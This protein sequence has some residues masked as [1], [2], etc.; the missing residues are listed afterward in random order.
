MALLCGLEPAPVENCRVL[1]LACGEGANLIPM[2][3]ELP[4]SRFVGFDAAALSIT[5]GYETIDAL[6]LSNIE[7]TATSIQDL[8]PG[9]GEFDYIVAHGVYS[10]VPEEVRDALLAV[11]KRHLAPHGVAYVSY[12]AYPGGHFRELVREMMLF[13]AGEIED[14]AQ[15]VGGGI[16]FVRF[17]R[18]LHPEQ[19]PY[20]AVLDLELER[21]ASDPNYVFHDDF[22]ETNTPVYFSQFAEHAQSHGL[23][24]LAEASMVFFGDPLLKGDTGRKLRELSGKNLIAREQ[25]L[26]FIRGT[27][28][29]QSLLCH[30][31][32]E[33][34][35]EPNVSRLLELYAASA[36]RPD[37]KDPD[38]RSDSVLS[39]KALGGVVEVRQPL[40]KSAFF[41]LGE[42]W[43]EALRISDLLARARE[44]CGQPQASEPTSEELAMFSGALLHAASVPVLDLWA[45][46]PRFV[47]K[48]SERPMASPLCRLQI[49]QGDIVT[50]LHHL[51]LRVEDAPSR[52]LLTLLDGTRT[53]EELL[54][55]M[56]ALLTADPER[57]P[58]T[59]APDRAELDAVLVRMATRG[60][61]VA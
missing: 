20:T 50:T 41:L 12:S 3:V 45:T 17:V 56:Q 30:A 47:S 21:L 9:I 46:P 4:N 44:L 52:H 51:M 61:L 53:K 11:C 23:R 59:S 6:G 55:D 19:T 14:P 31:A 40:V 36:L 28:F 24:F 22:S 54:S 16:E 34:R 25:Y 1:E 39:F 38:F 37:A 10:W 42:A 2:A 29:R 48:V 8:D 57:P 60:L 7:L 13:H 58:G 27:P 18:S 35:S 26:D 49:Q 43:P 15:R 5:A 32:L 33:P